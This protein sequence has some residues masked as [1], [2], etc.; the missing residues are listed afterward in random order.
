MKTVEATREKCTTRLWGLNATVELPKEFTGIRI[1]VHNIQD[2]KEV[3][4]VCG[5]ML[6][7]APHALDNQK[8]TNIE[9]EHHPGEV[10][11]S[12]VLSASRG[13]DGQKAEH[14]RFNDAY[15]VS[16]NYGGLRGTKDKRIIIE[17]A[18]LKPSLDLPK[19]M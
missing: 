16:V 15:V 10:I 8:P 18:L 3:H 5:Y 13:R 2:P 19:P 4:A 14:R 11:S 17:A 9:I 7:F 6:R 1:G 12:S